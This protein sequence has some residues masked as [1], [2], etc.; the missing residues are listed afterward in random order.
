MAALVASVL[1]A[2]VFARYGTGDHGVL[3][4]LQ[5]TALWS[6]LLFWLAYIG[7]AT[8]RLFGPCFAPLAQRGRE[9]GLAFASAQL[10]H[11][12]LVLWLIYLK[13]GPRGGMV[14]FWVGVLCVYLLVLFSFAPLRKAL[15]TPLGQTFRTAALE[16]IALAFATDFILIPLNGPGNYPLR[17]VS[18]TVMLVGGMGLRVASFA[19]YCYPDHTRD[20]RRPSAAATAAGLLLFVS[21]GVGLWDLFHGLTRLAMTVASIFIAAGTYNAWCSLNSK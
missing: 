21:I 18:M 7:G 6:F 4:A 1:A 20:L 16:Y 12:S 14:F 13:P 5:I 3:R 11:V 2:V 9:L 17:Y 10:I 8:A 15:G 19:G